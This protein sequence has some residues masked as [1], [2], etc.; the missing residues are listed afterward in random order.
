MEHHN[1]LHN[2]KTYYWNVAILA[3]SQ[4]LD[5]VATRG[6]IAKQ[7][8]WVEDSPRK[9]YILSHMELMTV[10]KVIAIPTLIVIVGYLAEKKLSHHQTKITF[11]MRLLNTLMVSAVVVNTGLNLYSFT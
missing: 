8:D 4:W 6:M 9:E 5:L 11:V 2:P 3:T 10:L 1:S 7:G